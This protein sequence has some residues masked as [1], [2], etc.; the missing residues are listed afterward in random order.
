M[1]VLKAVLPVAGLGTR[2][3]PATKKLDVVVTASDVENHKPFPDTFLVAA[4]HL[5]LE[6]SQCLVYIKRFFKISTDNT[7]KLLR[8]ETRFLWRFL[9]E[10]NGFQVVDLGDSLSCQL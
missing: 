8:R 7:V 5:G 2:M 1:K 6:A 3:L 10:L 9:L 4:E